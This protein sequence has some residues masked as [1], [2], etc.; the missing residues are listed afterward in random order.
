MKQKKKKTGL[1]TPVAPSIRVWKFKGENIAIESSDV[2]GWG[3]GVSELWGL[4]DCCLSERESVTQ[5]AKVPYTLS[6]GSREQWHIVP[7]S[8]CLESLTA[9][10]NVIRRHKGQKSMQS[11][12]RWHRA[13]L[14]I[15][16]YGD[17]RGGLMLNWSWGDVSVYVCVSVYGGGTDMFE[18]WAP[19]WP[20][21]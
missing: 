3:R 9:R 6:P 5:N 19:K 17:A 21:C 20:Q 14:F 8:S 15:D 7:A 16:H 11:I 1:R 4:P 13:V 2:C 10:I 12:S 18:R